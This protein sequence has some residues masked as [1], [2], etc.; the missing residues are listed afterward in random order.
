MP[1][2][3]LTAGR[4]MCAAAVLTALVPATAMSQDNAD[5]EGIVRITDV[6]P[7]SEPHTQQVSG[8]YGASCNTPGGSCNTPG[9]TCSQGEQ[10]QGEDIHCDSH[11]IPCISCGTVFAIATWPVCAAYNSS[12]CTKWRAHCFHKASEAIGVEDECEDEDGKRNPARCGYFHPYGKAPHHGQYHMT[13]AV[14]PSYFDSRDDDVY[15]AQGYGVPMAVPL[16]PNVRYSYNYSWGIPS[17]RITPIYRTLPYATAPT[18]PAGAVNYPT[19]AIPV[20]PTP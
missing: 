10:C 13:Y 15:A 3:Y 17:S 2:K 5:R 18:M 4:Y 19:P 7:G 11:S 9:A 14:N 12:F 20:P 6:R 8:E 16:A 1:T